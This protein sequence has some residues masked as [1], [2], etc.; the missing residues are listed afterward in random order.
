MKKFEKKFEEGQRFSRHPYI[1]GPPSNT[2]YHFCSDALKSPKNRG[3]KNIIF[4][5]VCYKFFL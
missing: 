5:S 2:L 3:V 1:G 4:A